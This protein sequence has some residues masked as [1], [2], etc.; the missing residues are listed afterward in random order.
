MDK[1]QISNIRTFLMIE[2][3][4]KRLDDLLKL[5]VPGEYNDFF[6]RYEQLDAAI[7]QHTE[8]I[9]L[10]D[11]YQQQVRLKHLELVTK[12]NQILGDQLHGHPVI[13]WVYSTINPHTQYK[14]LKVIVNHQGTHFTSEEIQN[15]LYLDQ[16][17]SQAQ[18]NILALSTFIGIGLTQQYSS[19][20][21]LFLDDPIQSMD[22]VNVLA[23]IDVLR[24]VLNS[25]SN[26][27]RF[28]ISTHDDNFAELLAVK[29][30][31]KN[32]SQYFIEGYGP[33]G[34]VVRKQN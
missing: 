25:E 10:I 34:P 13:T 17:F 9:D 24:A 4:I 1:N 16:I 6:S 8:K 27:K 2:L 26:K 14:D 29:M 33:E 30:R 20:D 18:L 15:N 28:I 32:V 5:R 7:R 21:Q 22:D 23:F 19:L 3:L 12:Q 11:T 31:N